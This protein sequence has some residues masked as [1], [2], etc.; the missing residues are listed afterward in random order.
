MQFLSKLQERDFLSL[1]DIDLFAAQRD[2]GHPVLPLNLVQS[3]DLRVKVCDRNLRSCKTPDF[4]EPLD[5]KRA[6]HGSN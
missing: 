3:S 1:G 2:L 6:I 4:L 5:S